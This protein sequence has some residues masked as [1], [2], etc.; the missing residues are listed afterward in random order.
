MK[1][2][3]QLCALVCALGLALSVPAGAAY[4]DLNPKAWYYNDVQKA[5]DGGL[6]TG[7][8]ASSFSPLAPVTRATVLAVLWRM[9]GSPETKAE[10]GFTDIAPKDWYYAPAAWA[11]Q[12]GIATGHRDGSFDP[13]GNVTRQ[14]LA[15]FLY[16]YATYKKDIIAKGVLEA[17]PDGDKVAG[18]ALPGMQHAL[19]A[20]LMTGNGA[21]ELDPTGI[22]N[23]AE[24]AVI[25]G[26]L[27]V[28][29][30]G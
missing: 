2:G 4:E 23:R 17:Y 21:G 24:L 22:A 3:I 10:P 16:R 15:M 14:E 25:L 26:R 19:G 30:Q 27:A 9:E 20:G 13:K 6:M 8:N 5:I 29:P 1:R 12:A 7:T 18:W 11:K 28:K